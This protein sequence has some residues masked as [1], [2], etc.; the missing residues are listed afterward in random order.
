VPGCRYAP[1]FGRMA[2]AVPAPWRN[3]GAVNARYPHGIGKVGAHDHVTSGEPVT[4]FRRSNKLYATA[5]RWNRRLDR[6]KNGIACE[7]R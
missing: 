6:D 2:A 5:M 4:T 1:V 3:C 7:K